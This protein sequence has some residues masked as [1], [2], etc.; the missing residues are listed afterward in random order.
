MTIDDNPRPKSTIAEVQ[1][2]SRGQ[3]LNAL[4]A[5]HREFLGHLI[6]R[7]IGAEPSEF[8]STVDQLEKVLTS[9]EKLSIERIS[10]D[11]EE[12]KEKI[13]AAFHE[14]Q[15]RDARKSGKNVRI[16]TAKVSYGKL[17]SPSIM[18]L[19]LLIL[20]CNTQLNR[21]KYHSSGR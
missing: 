10:A 6:G 4:S 15:E 17:D 20:E 1:S 14:W 9:D 13:W 5:N 12:Q 19:D 3:V 21:L 18:V 7:L 11:L 2:N 8:A 16:V